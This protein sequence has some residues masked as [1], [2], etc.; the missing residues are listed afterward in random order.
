[1]PAGDLELRTLT[2]LD[3]LETFREEWDELVRAMPRPSPW[4][5]HAWLTE[6]WRH[7]GDGAELR[8]HVALR[9]GRLVAALPLFVRRRYGVRVVDFFG[10]FRAA[11][12]DV[13]AADGDEEAVG[14]LAAQLAGGDHDVADIFGLHGASRLAAALGDRLRLELRVESPVLDLSDGWDAIYRR[15]TD[16]KKR[17]QHKRRRK[18]LAELG[19]LGMTVARTPQEID[20]LLDA[21]FDLHTLRWEGRPDGSGFATPVGR[22]FHRAA[23]CRLA[24]QD[25]PR[26]V[27]L[28]LDEQPVAFHYYFAF[29]GRM[30][31]HR[32]AFDPRLSRFSPGLVNTLDALQEAAREGL[33]TVEYLGG[34]ERYK[35]ELSDHFDPLY[36]GFGLARSPQGHALLHAR[37]ATIGVRRR[38]KRS[39]RLRRV[40]F[41]RLAPL[42][43]VSGALRR[44]AAR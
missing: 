9:D 11:P 3:E 4:L 41:E 5:L 21:A 8:V 38:L 34:G 13:L 12:V 29:C 20:D 19:V 10:H 18:Q 1:V 7:Y 32:L 33:T 44:R 24:E 27:F 37:L 43:R 26:L 35:L 6:W 31:V 23:A 28:T 16:S 25:I 30:F 15:H 14:A 2:R 22:R 40:Y 36:E 42:R 39:T 17:N